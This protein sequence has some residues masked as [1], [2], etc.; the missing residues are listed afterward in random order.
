MTKWGALC[1][2]ANHTCPVLNPFAV[3]AVGI[4]LLMLVLKSRT[5]PFAEYLRPKYGFPM[6]LAEV[7]PV[8][9]VEGSMKRYGTPMSTP[10]CLPHV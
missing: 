1:R 9:E 8:F 5:D 2:H 6:P 7:V 4:A 3:L 10:K